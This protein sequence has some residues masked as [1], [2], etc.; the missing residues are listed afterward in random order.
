VAVPPTNC[1]DRRS[2]QSICGGKVIQ[3]WLG[4]ALVLAADGDLL[5]L[6]LVREGRDFT[7]FGA[8]CAQL[9]S[10]GFSA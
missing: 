10:R 3:G 5:A 8:T 1:A 2:T 7:R 6:D 9:T 4:F